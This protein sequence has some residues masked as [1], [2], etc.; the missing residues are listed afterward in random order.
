MPS[1]GTVNQ[2]KLKAF[3]GDVDFGDLD[4]EVIERLS[5]LISSGDGTDFTSDDLYLY[6]ANN[7]KMAE[8][9]SNVSTGEAGVNKVKGDGSREKL[10]GI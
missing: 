1:T 7:K 4:D 10:G 8:A 9:F 3:L 5:E 2:H 6:I